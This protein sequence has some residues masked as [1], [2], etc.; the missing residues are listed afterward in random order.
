MTYLTEARQGFQLH[1]RTS[2]F[3]PKIVARHNYMLS[4]FTKSVNV[5]FLGGTAKETVAH[6]DDRFFAI[7]L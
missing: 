6:T 1:L 4:Q 2:N 7:R 3:T 5:E